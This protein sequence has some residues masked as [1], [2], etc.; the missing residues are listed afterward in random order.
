[1]VKKLFLLSILFPFLSY[2]MDQT[3]TK[4]TLLEKR[5][6]LINKAANLSIKSFFSQ[7]DANTIEEMH[8]RFGKLEG[9]QE[10]WNKNQ[11]EFYDN[12]ETIQTDQQFNYCEVAQ[13]VYLSVPKGVQPKEI[14]DNV[15]FW[16]FIIEKQ[17]ILKGIK[18][19]SRGGICL[20][21][22]P[23]REE[24]KTQ[25]NDDGQ[26]TVPKIPVQAPKKGSLS[27][28]NKVIAV[29]VIGLAAYGAI[30][31]MKQLYNR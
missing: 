25:I 28:L 7:A 13:G 18:Q 15:N 19:D 16:Q 21:F 3:M 31:L 11:Q 8:A 10:L 29:P 9:L 22:F 20:P 4:D 26:T 30:H 5:Q 17:E 24:N 1:M 14:F 6:E 27:H 2:S 12:F 23:H